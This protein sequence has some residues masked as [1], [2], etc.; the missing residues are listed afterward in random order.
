MYGNGIRTSRGTVHAT[1]PD[2]FICSVHTSHSI[3]YSLIVQTETLHAKCSKIRY[4]WTTASAMSARGNVCSLQLEVR[5]A[6]RV[7]ARLSCVRT[8]LGRLESA[9]QRQRQAPR[10]DLTPSLP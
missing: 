4:G 1:L 10:H 7:S 2:S 5:Q 8:A 3:G 9:A 6:S